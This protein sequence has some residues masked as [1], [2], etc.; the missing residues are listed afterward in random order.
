MLPNKEF[1]LRFQELCSHISTQIYDTFFIS[2]KNGAIDSYP[3]L[4][5]K[6]FCKSWHTRRI[7]YKNIGK[8]A[9]KKIAYEF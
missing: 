6:I 9:A 3:S 1:Y 2:Q 4:L 5:P 7:E 8:I